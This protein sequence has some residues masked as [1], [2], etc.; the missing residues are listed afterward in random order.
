MVVPFF[1][2]CPTLLN[3][4]E[5]SEPEQFVAEV[6]E[7]C[8]TRSRKQIKGMV[9]KVVREIHLLKKKQISDGWFRRF[10]EQ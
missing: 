7:I 2:Y 8:Y 9:E 5:E 10:L 1:Q 3:N 4:E 6:S